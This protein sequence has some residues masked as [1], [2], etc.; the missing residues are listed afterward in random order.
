MSTEMPSWWND[1]DQL[2][3]VLRDLLKH[4]RRRASTFDP[5]RTEGWLYHSGFCLA[6]GPWRYVEEVD[7]VGEAPFEVG[8][9]LVNRM[10]A[11]L[12][13]LTW[14]QPGRA[15]IHEA[16]FRIEQIYYDDE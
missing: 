8:I 3:T 9:V 14:D 15:A 12:Q 2:Y 4:L 11:R 10:L 6:D 7:V 13:D 1:P 16:H 5:D